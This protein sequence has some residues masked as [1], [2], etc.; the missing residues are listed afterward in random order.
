VAGLISRAFR[1]AAPPDGMPPVAPGPQGIRQ[2][3]RDDRPPREIFVDA[4]YMTGGV[5]PEH[6]PCG[7]D[8][9]KSGEA[10]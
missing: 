5:R 3:Q 7:R 4:G 1:R 2:P 8:P 10:P 6:D 9:I